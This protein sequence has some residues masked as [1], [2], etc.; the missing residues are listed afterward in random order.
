MTAMGALLPEGRRG[1][2]PVSGLA[3]SILKGELVESGLTAF[4]QLRGKSCQS[5][6]DP[7]QPLSCLRGD[8]RSGRSASR[9]GRFAENAR[10]SRADATY[11]LLVVGQFELFP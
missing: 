6:I 5:Q 1:E 9:S 3:K 8:P 7:T 10:F 2:R 11:R 4:G